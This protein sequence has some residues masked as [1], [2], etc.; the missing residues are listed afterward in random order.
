MGEC[1]QPE[2]EE[3]EKTPTNNS[4]QKKYGKDDRLSLNFKSQPKSELKQS[5]TLDFGSLKLE[6]SDSKT[7]KKQILKKSISSGRSG[8]KKEVVA[9]V[10]TL[11]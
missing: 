7:D 5:K 8:N 10:C 9:I 2:P 4:S 11:Y 1:H 6:A 3:E